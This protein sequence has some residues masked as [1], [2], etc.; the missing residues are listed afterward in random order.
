MPAST[1]LLGGNHVNDETTTTET[2]SQGRQLSRRSVV[3]T[4]ANAVWAVPLVQVAAAAPALA[5]STI[6]DIFL[7]GTPTV[8]VTGNPA[9]DV[10]V[11]G[12]VVLNDGP[13]PL[14]GVKVLLTSSKT[15]WAATQPSNPTWVLTGQGTAVLTCTYSGTVPVNKT[16]GSPLPSIN[17]ALHAAGTT[18]ITVSAAI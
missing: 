3:R 6:N 7:V 15:N 10:A 9:K 18:T 11:T 17:A 1:T 4:A 2:T 13:N 14:T 16:V 8:N 12:I 5:N